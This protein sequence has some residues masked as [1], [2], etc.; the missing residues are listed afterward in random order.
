MKLGHIK[1]MDQVFSLYFSMTTGVRN[2]L[3]DST[4]VMHFVDEMREMIEKSAPLKN[5]LFDTT[6]PHGDVVLTESS[7]MKPGVGWIT[8]HATEG[9]RHGIHEWCIK[10]ENQGET[11]DGSGLMLGI[12]PNNYSRYDTFISQGGGWCLSRAGKFY[13]QW[14]RLNSSNGTNNSVTFGKDDRVIL[15]LDYDNARL[16][17]RVGANV[18]VGEVSNLAPEVFPAVS[19][20]Y[21]QQQVR[22]EYHIVH[23]RN[24]RQVCWVDRLLLRP[25]TAFMSF[26]L[27]QLGT[28]KL[29]SFVFSPIFVDRAAKSKKLDKKNGRK[30]G[31][32]NLPLTS[33]G[34]PS[35][36][37]FLPSS[38]S[39]STR[40]SS[41]HRVVGGLQEV[42][43]SDEPDMQGSFKCHTEGTSRNCSPYSLDAAAGRMIILCNTFSLL[44]RYTEGAPPKSTY[45]SSNITAEYLRKRMHEVHRSRDPNSKESI[46]Y[47]G[48]NATLNCGAIIMSHMFTHVAGDP[49]CAIALPLIFSLMDYLESLPLFGLSEGQQSPILSPEILQLA[50]DNIVTLLENASQKE[51]FESETLNPLTV[52]LVELA[53]LLALQRGLVSEVLRACRFLFR[54]PN[55]IVSPRL[56]EWLR[57][58]SYKL[59]PHVAIPDIYSAIQYASE[60]ADNL[61]ITGISTKTKVFSTAFY[62]EIIYIHSSEGLSKWGKSGPVFIKLFNTLEPDSCYKNVEKSSIAATTTKILFC[63][64]CMPRENIAVVVYSV[65]LQVQQIFT[66]KNL[67]DWPSTLL[68]PIITSGSSDEVFVLHVSQ[69]NS[70]GDDNNRLSASAGSLPPSLAGRSPAAACNNQPINSSPLLS[71]PAKANLILSAFDF[72][73]STPKVHWRTNLCLHPTEQFTLSHCLALQKSSEVDLGSPDEVLSSI[74]GHV[75]IELYIMLLEKE[76]VATTIYQHGCSHTS[77]EVFIETAKLEGA[78]CIRGGYRHDTHGSSV[79]FAPVPPSSETRFMHIALVFCGSWKLYFDG[80]DVGG[81]LGLQASVFSPRQK[82]TIGPKCICRLAGLRVWRRSRGTREIARDYMRILSG[83]EDGLVCQMFFNEPSGNVVFNYVSHSSAQ[84]GMCTGKYSHVRI[85]NHPLN[86]YVSPDAMVPSLLPLHNWCDTSSASL[87]TCGNLIGLTHKLT[88]TA[89]YA[90]KAG[91][92]ALFFDAQSGVAHRSMC[93]IP[94]HYKTKGS[95]GFDHAGRLVELVETINK[96]K[97]SGAT[98]NSEGVLSV[99][100]FSIEE[101][102]ESKANNTI[103]RYSVFRHPSGMFTTA[104]DCTSKCSDK[105]PKPPQSP[106]R[107]VQ[108]DLDKEGGGNLLF[109]QMPFSAV[110]NVD[111]ESLTFMQLA[112]WLLHLLCKHAEREPEGN[113]MLFSH[114]ADD[115]SRQCVEEIKILLME[116]F[117]VVKGS[118][119]R[120]AVSFKSPVST[121]VIYCVLCILLRL[122][123][124][125]RAFSLHPSV[126]GLN[127]MDNESRGDGTA[128]DTNMWIHRASFSSYVSGSPLANGG[129]TNPTNSFSACNLNSTN[130]SIHTIGGAECNNSSSNTDDFHGFHTNKTGQGLSTNSASTSLDSADIL[131]GLLGDLVNESGTTISPHL[132]NVAKAVLFEGI[133]LFFPSVRCRVNLLR[134]MLSTQP[135][136]SL[137]TP[138]SGIHLSQSQNTTPLTPAEKTPAAELLMN[139]MV[140]SLGTV[141]SAMTLL[142]SIHDDSEKHSPA[143]CQSDLQDVSGMQY[144]ERTLEA[145]IEESLFQLSR[146]SLQDVQNSPS[147]LSGEGKNNEPDGLGLGNSFSLMDSVVLVDSSHSVSQRCRLIVSLTEAIG[148]LQL[149]LL[150]SCFQGR[151]TENQIATTLTTDLFS[152]PIAT[153]S[154]PHV[155]AYYAKLFQAAQEGLRLM[156]GKSFSDMGLSCSLNEKHLRWQL[157][158]FHCSFMSSLLYT[159]ISAIPMAVTVEDAEWYL[160]QLQTLLPLCEE[161]KKASHRLREKWQFCVEIPQTPADALHDTVF[162]TSSWIAT[163]MAQHSVVPTPP[164]I[165]LP[166]DDS[167]TGA[168]GAEGAGS[169]SFSN[170]SIGPHEGE[171][172]AN[173]KEEKD[174]HSLM[175]P[176][177]PGV[178]IRPRSALM[179]LCDHPLLSGGLS[180]EAGEHPSKM[181]PVCPRRQAVI[182]LLKEKNHLLRLQRPIDPLGSMAPP[183]FAHAVSYMALTAIYLSNTPSLHLFSQSRLDELV[184]QTMK[185]V[186]PVRTAWLNELT[187]KS[188]DIRLSAGQE[189]VQR[190]K[191]LLCFTSAHSI[192]PTKE[193]STFDP[194]ARS[195]CTD[196]DILQGL[197]DIRHAPDFPSNAAGRWRWAISQLR[198]RRLRQRADHFTNTALSLSESVRLV[199]L[200]ASPKK[201]GEEDISADAIKTECRKRNKYAAI[202]VRG[203]QHFLRLLLRDPTAVQNISLV[204]TCSQSQLQTHFLDGVSG[205][206]RRIVQQISGTLYQLIQ[207]LKNLSLSPPTL[208]CNTAVAGDSGLTGSSTLSSVLS[209][210]INRTWEPRDFIFISRLRVLEVIFNLSC[211]IFTSS[212]ETGEQCLK[213]LGEVERSHR[214][215]EKEYAKYLMMRSKETSEE[216]Q[217]EKSLIRTPEER[218]QHSA[219]SCLKNLA[220][221]SAA[222]LC[223]DLPVT[224]ACGCC[225]F[226]CQLFSSINQELQHCHNYLA[227]KDI[228]PEDSDRISD[229]VHLLTSLVGVVVAALP[230][231]AQIIGELHHSMTMMAC[232]LSLFVK[233]DSFCCC[234]NSFALRGA[235]CLRVSGKLLSHINPKVANHYF[236]DNAKVKSISAVYFHT[237][238][239]NLNATL[240]FFFSLIVRSLI[241]GGLNSV[242]QHLILAVREL[243]HIPRWGELLEHMAPAFHENLSAFTAAAIGGGASTESN[244]LHFRTSAALKMYVWGSCLGGSL[245]FLP[246]PGLQA[247]YVKEDSFLQH[248]CFILDCERGNITVASTK[249][250]LCKPEDISSGILS[251]MNDPFNPEETAPV[252]EKDK[253]I[254][255]DNIF[256]PNFEHQVQT[257]AYRWTLEKFVA[258]CLEKIIPIIEG[259]NRIPLDLIVFTSFLGIALKLVKQPDL[260]MSLINK[261]CIRLI[262]RFASRCVL[263]D[264]LPVIHLKEFAA[265]AIHFAM[266]SLFSPNKNIA[267]AQSAVERGSKLSPDLKALWSPSWTS[268][269]PGGAGPGGGRRT[270]LVPTPPTLF[271]WTQARYKL[272]N[273]REEPSSNSTMPMGFP[274]IP[275][276]RPPSLPSVV[277]C[278]PVGKTKNPAYVAVSRAPEAGRDACLLDWGPGGI[279]IEAAFFLSDRAFP[280]LGEDFTIPSTWGRP[281]LTFDF[282]TAFVSQDI[283][284]GGVKEIPLLHVFVRGREIICKLLL[285][286]QNNVEVTLVL[287]LYDWDTFMYI[288]AFLDCE[289]LTLWKGRDRATKRFSDEVSFLLEQRRVLSYKQGG[290]TLLLIGT[291]PQSTTEAEGSIGEDVESEDHYLLLRDIHISNASKSSMSLLS[292]ADEVLREQALKPHG[293]EEDICYFPFSE[294]TGN[295]VVSSNQRCIGV[296]KGNVRWVPYTRKGIPPFSLDCTEKLN[297]G[298]NPG[299][300]SMLPRKEIQ[301]LFASL[302]LG[303]LEYMSLS[304]L[305]S[306]SAHLCRMTV[307]EALQQSMSP[308]YDLFVIA[309]KMERTFEVVK[310][311]EEGNWAKQLGNLLRYSDAGV[312]QRDH[313][314]LIRRFVEQSVLYCSK[315]ETDIRN[316]FEETVNAV[317][318]TIHSSTEVF[319]VEIP[320]V[321]QSAKGYPLM[322]LSFINGGDGCISFNVKSCILEHANIFKDRSQKTILAKFPDN[323]GCWLDYP[324]PVDT[325]WLYV[326]NFPFPRH[327]E[328]GARMIA[329]NILLRSMRPA[330]MSAFFH[331]ACIAVMQK[332]PKHEQSLPYFLSSPLMSAML[333]RENTGDS[334]QDVIHA[335]SILCSILHLWSHFPDAQPFDRSPL[336]IMMSA[337]NTCLVSLLHRCATG[338]EYGQNLL[339]ALETYNSYTRQ[340]V[341]VLMA[342]IRLENVWKRKSYRTSVW[343]RWH[344]LSRLWEQSTTQITIVKDEGDSSTRNGASSRKFKVVRRHIRVADCIANRQRRLIELEPIEHP[345][346][347]PLVVIHQRGSGEWFVR[348]E[349]DPM[350]VRSSV[351]FT[352]G[353]F[354]FEVRT[355]DSNVNINLLTVGVVTEKWIQ[356]SSEGPC[357]LEQDPDSWCFDIAHVSAYFQGCPAEFAN[358]AKWKMGDVGGILL[359]LEANR[360]VCFHNNRQVSSCEKLKSFGCTSTSS[361]PIFFPVVRFGSCGCNINFGSAS[362]SCP[363]PPAALPVDP[364]FFHTPE[365]TRMWLMVSALEWADQLEDG[366]GSEGPHG[367]LTS[368]EANIQHAL[369]LQKAFPFSLGNYCKPWAQQRVRPLAKR[370][371]LQSSALCTF[372]QHISKY[373]V[374]RSGTLSVDLLSSSEKL[375]TIGNEARVDDTPCLIRGSV[376]VFSG[377]WY[378]E[379]VTRDE[380]GLSIGWAA[381]DHLGEW[382]RTRFLGDDEYSWAL[383]GGRMIAKHNKRQ[384]NLNRHSFRSGNVVGCLL[385]CDAGTISYT[386]NGN[387]QREVHNTT[388][389]G[390]LFRGVKAFPGGITPAVSMEAKSDATF[391]WNHEDLLYLPPGYKPLGSSS[392]L[393]EGLTDY[394]LFSMDAYSLENGSS[395]IALQKFESE[396]EKQAIGYD[397]ETMEKI[398]HLTSR[399]M[400]VNHMNL[401]VYCLEQALGILPGDMKEEDKEV[402]QKKKV[403]VDFPHDERKIGNRMASTLGLSVAEL[404]SYLL[405]LHIL[406]AAVERIFPFCYEG[407]L[408]IDA[409]PVWFA[410]SPISTAYRALKK[411]CLSYFNLRVLRR[412]LM[413]TNRPGVKLKLTLHRRKAVML[414]LS[415]KENLGLRLKESLFGQV[416]HLLSSKPSSLF[417]TNKKLWSVCFLG[418]GADDVGGPYRES[419]SQICTE[420]MGP[421]LSLFV[422][423]ANQANEIGDSR[424][425]FVLSPAVHSP[426][427]LGMF[428]FLGRLIGGC[429]RSAEPLSLS[430]PSVA[431]K[432]L[433]GELPDISDLERIDVCTVQSLQYIAN[434]I[435]SAPAGCGSNDGK[436][437]VAPSIALEETKKMDKELSE[438]I[439]DGF[440]VMDDMGF[441]H[442]LTTFVPFLDVNDHN[443]VYYILLTVF[444]KLHVLGSAPLEALREGFF[445][446]IP[447]YHVSCLK[448]YE[449]E[450]VVCGQ[451]DYDPDDLLNNARYENISPED[452]RVVYLREVLKEFTSHQRASFM[453]FVTGRERLP[454]GI[455]IRIMRDHSQP[456]SDVSVGE[457]E[458]QSRSSPNAHFTVNPV[459]VDRRRS[460]APPITRTATPNMG[461]PEQKNSPFSDDSEPYDDARLPHAS[462]CFY[463]LSLPK[464]SCKEVLKEK[465]LFAIEQCLDIDADFRVRDQDMSL[466]DNQPAL[467]PVSVD[468]EEFEDYSH[469]R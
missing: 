399:S 289:S 15:L 113:G 303:G 215:A 153:S 190:M 9:I 326:R 101:D 220:L 188:K 461:S 282:F 278:F 162:F 187:G 301:A 4:A 268:T 283:G 86:S 322:P 335:S 429:L 211:S 94:S 137:L 141:Q 312:L 446:V 198:S 307:V 314:E 392:S 409:S 89:P 176:K 161:L 54:F 375:K 309:N 150:S 273:P 145:L 294:G 26:S 124:R 76:D 462:T 298:I 269:H 156:L 88:A 455:Q 85:R 450:A 390:V 230:S 287:Q 417:C 6:T 192:D 227:K 218:C 191:T 354:Y 22:F 170:P 308:D 222:A 442:R 405:V 246:S 160:T 372:L 445:Q 229:Q 90:V 259:Q 383:E 55:Q 260:C 99:V 111:Q 453:R 291:P 262:H 83:K 168:D 133:E 425:T 380:G 119:A 341:G 302:D 39:S 416:Y 460:G 444:Y 400:N 48:L 51:D 261:G 317:K 238:A 454:P 433:V 288:G 157:E 8:L 264:A 223:E 252:D 109:C 464:Y 297:T 414:G 146:R 323:K 339:P 247:R 2:Q 347:S 406:S 116:H 108:S 132:G 77:G 358:R 13:G 401:S 195:F 115:V 448:W 64:D 357:A 45:L 155:T 169:P 200:I 231:Q 361:L 175:A 440:F 381:A 436:T 296:L 369:K 125:V 306:L 378:Y 420:L 120:R 184:A 356:K 344:R 71:E 159:A 371:Q 300:F 112:S 205:G 173:E 352:K 465:L 313:L 217:S 366:S 110:S 251:R 340:L 305:E 310:I 398:I 52:S 106:S 209:D 221:Q 19:L 149:L 1:P 421:M 279:S 441:R 183:E 391:M 388:G 318:D 463:W 47:S 379:V 437:M 397:A 21:K 53:V 11:T 377:K 199:S 438:L 82:W 100:S 214:A 270:V 292:V 395:P 316:F 332:F 236:H 337:L 201:E 467:A 131:L 138:S 353:R 102:S 241:G 226:L 20:H 44:Q 36:S 143:C 216:D 349:K 105:S 426:I 257:P 67:P 431:W 37:T 275:P 272:I 202:R 443:A 24:A 72:S 92:A 430:L 410:F 203:F 91:Q 434:L 80:V 281:E 27:A 364:S 148:S 266:K 225:A 210:I 423:S 331:A 144:I 213:Q 280:A 194:C 295:T 171:S 334:D 23:N 166:R 468:D 122:V 338:Q 311:F 10:I 185:R 30:T 139:A 154:Q 422:P 374:G 385:D 336:S 274:G 466:M 70:F 319:P 128:K 359:D 68:M 63:T 174:T 345:V 84:H 14:R 424:D 407:T 452:L 126:L 38:S 61:I 5:F 129:I 285:D 114:L 186:F 435:N 181:K 58:V 249:E 276:S 42:A 49:N 329:L 449:L 56:V 69:I 60:E 32:H 362:F 41:T 189:V 117:R 118:N 413:T 197:A 17:I 396:K 363:L 299:K 255:E 304:I 207:S 228:Q 107:S 219:L 459:G 206:D 382:N 333:P 28:L 237:C 79:V 250:T 373:A 172:S 196:I 321:A 284:D 193:E 376:C 74:G 235:A 18:V 165:S 147:M 412:L 163:L 234:T 271:S 328:G 65:T 293:A 12:V 46:S 370:R 245:L 330:V 204:L 164:S 242:S 290:I 386:I 263:R 239:S 232:T 179:K 342:A 403:A 96:S 256:M 35:N 432:A 29:D 325:T 368:V 348:S 95:L 98:S 87:F 360:L 240:C 351:G 59:Q 208:N 346:T 34:G 456:N 142:T 457:G 389:D 365:D 243:L 253:S 315:S 31:T 57:R 50:V 167:T 97:L 244:D 151:G 418:E 180:S 140:S 81:S 411:Y 394:F 7:A 75:T 439:P 224:P 428:Q 343:E 355:P 93:V 384:I 134:E 427:E 25:P 62:H 212:E 258:P 3:C 254:S 127:V 458:R 73:C 121:M 182:F 327:V 136:S 387:I 320:S 152:F 277:L 469:L 33:T 177:P 324:I 419:L 158:L 66:V 350:T 267:E 135:Q 402:S 367:Y 78:L 248:E 123:R 404:R 103:P 265:Y 451:S 16:T 415:P 130:P 43:L 178:V 104:Q 40:Y 393:T 447:F 233:Y 286:G 408:T